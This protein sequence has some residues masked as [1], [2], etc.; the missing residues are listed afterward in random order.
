MSATLGILGVLLQTAA[1]LFDWSTAALLV[2]VGMTVVG[3][4]M[5]YGAWWETQHKLNALRDES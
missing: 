4:L 1:V 5:L 2:G 3:A